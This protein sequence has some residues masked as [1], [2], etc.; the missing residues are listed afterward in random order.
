V[1]GIPTTIPFHQLVVED[2]LFQAGDVYT[3]FVEQRILN[4]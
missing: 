1:V 4:R 3:D 2:E